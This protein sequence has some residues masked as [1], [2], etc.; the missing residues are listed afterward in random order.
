MTSTLPSRCS[1]AMKS[2]VG[3][4]AI[5]VSPTL[6]KAGNS[7]IDEIAMLVRDGDPR[8]AL[9]ESTFDG[10][11]P[12]IPDLMTA[13]EDEKHAERLRNLRGAK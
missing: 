13:T 6:E 7:V 8:L 2:N 11:V 9:L 12:L 3:L 5:V 1:A 10:L 4:K